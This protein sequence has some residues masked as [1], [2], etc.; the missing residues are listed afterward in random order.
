M[1][2]QAIAR[3]EEKYLKEWIEHHINLGIE[4]IFLYDNKMLRIQKH[5]VRNKN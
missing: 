2:I 5:T 4:H 3:Q 1:V